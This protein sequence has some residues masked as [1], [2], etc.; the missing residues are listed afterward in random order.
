MNNNIQFLYKY[1]KKKNVDVDYSDLETGISSHPNYP[2]I[3]SYADTL[4]MMNIRYNIYNYPDIENETDRKDLAIFYDRSGD[5]KFE[6]IKSQNLNTLKES[7]VLIAEELP[8]K[9][10]LKFNLKTA[11]LFVVFLLL[12]FICSIFRSPYIPVLSLCAVI[13]VYISYS[14]LSIELGIESDFSNKFC[15][16][17]EE[18]SSCSSIINSDKK[19]PVKLGHLSF[20]FF[21]QQFFLLAFSIAVPEF[22]SIFFIGIMLSLPLTFYSLYFQLVIEKKFCTVCLTIIAILYIQILISIISFNKLPFNLNFNKILLFLIIIAGAYLITHF[23]SENAALVERLKKTNNG[24]IKFYRNFDLFK[25]S[26]IKSKRIDFD[27]ENLGVIIGER[28]DAKPLITMVSNP[29]CKYCKETYKNLWDLYNYESDNVVIQIIFYDKNFTSEGKEIIRN[30][31][32]HYL[33]AGGS[34]TLEMLANNYNFF[35]E[36]QYIND[37]LSSEIETQILSQNNFGLS[38]NFEH[39]P[40][41]LLNKYVFP[42]NYSRSFLRYF[43]PDLISDMKK[44]NNFSL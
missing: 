23:I 42:E 37:E 19:L 16:S 14:G 29:N 28:S 30:I 36:K 20:F 5:L 32:H 34:S 17:K 41:L 13:G 6:Y 35:E 12:L 2:D 22:Y 8:K 1:L 7:L 33:D 21:I 25:Y 26:L 10:T 9:W 31:L 38:T 40:T 44:S 15:S 39:S 4:D 18:K 11:F 3:L 27:L 24:L 43:I